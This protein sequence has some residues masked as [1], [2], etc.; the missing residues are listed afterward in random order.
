MFSFTAG[1]EAFS[2]SSRVRRRNSAFIKADRK[3]QG[4][5]VLSESFLTRRKNESLDI[6]LLNRS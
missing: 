3:V 2:S 1:S 5:L 4:S 6:S